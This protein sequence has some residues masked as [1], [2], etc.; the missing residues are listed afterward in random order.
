MQGNY[1]IPAN[2]KRAQLIFNIFR[3]IDLVIAIVG[4]SLTI[5]LFIIIQPYNLVWAI[6]TLLPLLICAFLV[7]PI[8]NYQNMLCVIQNVYKF[9]F[10]ERQEFKWKGWCAKDEFKE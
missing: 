1:L 9:Y 3:P 10:T 2:S 4:A 7:L 6:V 5:L 8:P